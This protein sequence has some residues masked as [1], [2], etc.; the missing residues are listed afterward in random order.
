MPYGSRLVIGL[1][2]PCGLHGGS[3][4][5]VPP[6][7][8]ENL[9][10]R[11]QTC[12]EHLLGSLPLFLSLLPSL[13]PSRA[14]SL[15]NLSLP[16]LSSASISSSLLLRLASLP[17]LWIPASNQRSGPITGVTAAQL[18]KR[19][20]RCW[21]TLHTAKCHLCITQDVLGMSLLAWHVSP[22]D[23]VFTLCVSTRKSS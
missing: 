21:S 16:F 18:A 7:E 3:W 4:A 13:R 8:A 20:L 22:K 12:W 10:P 2:Q 9:P 11:K 17:Y 1:F 5:D 23:I 19:S 6:A 15:L 14:A